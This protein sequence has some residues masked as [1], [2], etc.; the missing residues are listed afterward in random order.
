MFNYKLFGRNFVILNKYNLMKKISEKNKRGL[1][2]V[3]EGV[4]RAGKSTQLEKLKNYFI[5][6]KKELCS[7]VRFPGTVLFKVDRET[8][9]GKE[10][11]E[12]LKNYKSMEVRACHLLFSLNRWEKREEMLNLLADG[13]NVLVDRYAFSGVVYS[14]ANVKAFI[15]F[16]ELTLSG[17]SILTR[18]CLAPMLCSN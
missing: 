13:V 16:R 1:L 10:I 5:N 2:I 11:N 18:A 3:F 6:T 7:V 8:K 15:I 17:A 9:I 14:I 12:I 4:D